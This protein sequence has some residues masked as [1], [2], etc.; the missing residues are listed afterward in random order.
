MPHATLTATAAAGLVT[1]YVSGTG[2]GHLDLTCSGLD[3]M[4]EAG[5]DPGEHLNPRAA[6]LDELFDPD[7]GIVPCRICALETVLMELVTRPPL[8]GPKLFIVT[9][10]GVRN[11]SRRR[12]YAES[13]DAER[14]RVAKLR[15][16][17]EAR[18]IRV[19]KAAGLKWTTTP[20]GN[21]MYGFLEGNLAEALDERVHTFIS[22]DTPQM[23]VPADL[24]R[25]FWS[26][27]HSSTLDPN[28]AWTTAR[29]I[30]GKPAPAPEGPT[31]FC[32]PGCQ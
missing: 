18:V 31:T 8:G 22:R 20:Q 24:V 2:T 11:G 10:F 27:I 25:G 4:R 9:S 16:A 17:A 13:T 23:D 14:E 19:A 29:D 30:W 12:Y 32:W 15:A 6:T 21:V 5:R 1:A 26:M 28:Q 7:G 3:R